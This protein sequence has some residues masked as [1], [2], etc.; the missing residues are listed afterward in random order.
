MRGGSAPLDR[1]HP[2]LPSSA[3][4]PVRPRGSTRAAHARCARPPVAQ[5]ASRAH[6]SRVRLAWGVCAGDASDH[7]TREAPPLQAR[8][9]AR[10][11]AGCTAH[12]SALAAAAGSTHHA[13]DRPHG[14]RVHAC[15]WR[16]RDRTR[17]VRVRG[18]MSAPARSCTLALLAE[19]GARAGC[20]RRG[21]ASTSAFLTWHTLGIAA[22]TAA[23]RPRESHR[24]TAATAAATAAKITHARQ[25]S[26]ITRLDLP[27]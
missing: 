12:G 1:E 17:K 6:D 5:S 21:C 4:A 3:A 2:L 15:V 22:A 20:F 7:G 19:L 11:R 24:D 13:H 26:R 10:G 27:G 9:S 23:R 8:R 16:A 14:A 18:S 25:V